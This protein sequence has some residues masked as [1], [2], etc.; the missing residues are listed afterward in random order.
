MG[1]EDPLD[2]LDAVPGLEAQDRAAIRG[3]NA[4]ALLAAERSR[5]A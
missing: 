4:A 2:R 5:V 3:G 1:V